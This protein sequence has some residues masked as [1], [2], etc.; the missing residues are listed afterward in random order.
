MGH[1]FDR[2]SRSVLIYSRDS[3]TPLAVQTR[4]LL[5]KIIDGSFSPDRGRARR[6][7]E[8]L[9]EE[10]AEEAENDRERPPSNSESE[11]DLDVVN[12]STS[13]EPGGRVGAVVIPEA[14]SS[15]PRDHLYVHNISGIMHATYDLRK[16][17]CGR[18]LNKHYSCVTDVSTQ[19]GD[20]QACKHCS[21]VFEKDG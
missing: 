17:L 19:E 14:L 6:V 9:G 1:H 15:V 20:L 3:Y 7:A 16:L 10:S 11:T 21:V 5:D 12:P 8:L 18:E 2:E 4:R 13:F